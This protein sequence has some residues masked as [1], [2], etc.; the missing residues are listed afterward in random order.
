MLKIVT[1]NLNKFTEQVRKTATIFEI[2]IFKII[3]E[4]DQPLF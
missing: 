1:D 2:Y 3:T 4:K